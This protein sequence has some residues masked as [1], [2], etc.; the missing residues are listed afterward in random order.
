MEVA[1]RE[2]AIAIDANHT[3][4]ILSLLRTPIQIKN[5]APA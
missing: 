1:S 2:R 4:P 5:P 3:R